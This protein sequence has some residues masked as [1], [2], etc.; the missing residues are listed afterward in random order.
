MRQEV[1]CVHTIWR[2]GK[3]SIQK[4]SLRSCK[5]E[6][7]RMRDDINKERESL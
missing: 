7:E 4:S 6:A 5:E 1:L 2:I 3:Q